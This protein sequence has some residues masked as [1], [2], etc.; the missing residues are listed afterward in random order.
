MRATRIAITDLPEYTRAT[1]LEEFLRPLGA[2]KHVHIKHNARTDRSNREAVLQFHDFPVKIFGDFNEGNRN[3]MDRSVTLLFK[4]TY[5]RL[6]VLDVG[7]ERSMDTEDERVS[8]DAVNSV[9]SLNVSRVQLGTFVQEDLLYTPLTDALKGVSEAG[10]QLHFDDNK[11]RISWLIRGQYGVDFKFEFPFRYLSSQIIMEVDHEDDTYWLTFDLRHAPKIFRGAIGDVE[12][13]GVWEWRH[14]RKTIWNRIVSVEL[15]PDVDFGE[16]LVY[17]FAI[18]AVNGSA[19]LYRKF[20]RIAKICRSFHAGAPY[21]VN[22]RMRVL[23]ELP[24]SHAGWVDLD[25]LANDIPFHLFYLLQCLVSN[26]V[27]PKYA[28][29]AQFLE[30]MPVDD[31]YDFTIAALEMMLVAKERVYDPVETLTSCRMTPLKAK[32][33]VP[34]H[35]VLVRKVIVTPTRICY[36]VPTVKY[37]SPHY[38]TLRLNWGI[39]CCVITLS[40]PRTFF[41]SDSLMKIWKNTWMAQTLRMSSYRESW[42]SWTVV[43]AFPPK[44]FS[45]WH[46]R[47]VSCDSILAGSLHHSPRT[48][49]Q[50]TRTVS[51]LGWVILL[52]FV[53]LE[54][55]LLDLGNVSLVLRHSALFVNTS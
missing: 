16:H 12:E 51:V 33:Q 34:E 41:V 2:L 48:T 25:S 31:S 35:C 8:D 18:S 9:T 23:S 20:D 13:F 14:S 19:A 1:D 26:S 27:M 30:L 28:I 38:L 40:A 42:V 49:L 52:I 21:P 3:L 11:R 17:R 54:S 47:V 15:C 44:C 36:T 37:L 43:S 24:E 55:T 7:G 4:E 29:S 39:A 22:T 32:Q 45:F 6:V 46:S 5:V 50:L 10:M 53:R